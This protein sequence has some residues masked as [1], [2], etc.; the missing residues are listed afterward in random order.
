MV[1]GKSR[2]KLDDR[3]FAIKA[4]AAFRVLGGTF[5]EIPLVATSKDI[6]QKGLAT[7][8]IETLEEAAWKVTFSTLVEHHPRAS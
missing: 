8:L 1:Q 6:Q 3:A 4:V 7:L 5:M 2:R